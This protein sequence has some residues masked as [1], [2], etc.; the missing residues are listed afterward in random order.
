MLKYVKIGQRVQAAT[1][2]YAEDFGIVAEC[3][4]FGIIEE[5]VKG[6]DLVV[7]F[8][9]TKA[10]TYCGRDELNPI[11]FREYPVPCLIGT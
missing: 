10:R 2:I 1:V 6:G 11:P 7:Y 4:D 8:P 5:R 9:S 3:N